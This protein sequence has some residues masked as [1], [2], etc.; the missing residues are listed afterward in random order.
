MPAG[1]PTGREIGMRYEG[2]SDMEEK[3]MQWIRENADTEF[4]K[5]HQ[6]CKIHSLA[7]YQNYVPL[8]DY[9]DYEEAVQRMYQGETNVLTSYPLYCFV[10]TSGSVGK[11]KRIPL[12]EKGLVSFAIIYENTMRHVEGLAGKHLHLSVFPVIEHTWGEEMMVSEA[13]YHSLY[14]QGKIHLD[15]YVG[16]R[17]LFFTRETGDH[18]YIKLWTALQEEDLVSV[19]SIYLYDV[20]LFFRYLE[21]YGME[22]LAAMETGVIPAE[23]PLTQT[24]KQRLLTEYR[25]SGQRIRFLKK[26]LSQGT[27]GIAPRIWKRLRLISGIGGKFFCYREKLLRQYTGE[28]PWQ[29]FIYGSS[30]CLAGSAEGLENPL[31]SLVPD[32]GYFEFLDR[33]TGLV[34][35]RKQCRMQKIYE[36]VIT[37]RSGFYRYRSGD[38]V[39]V[40]E[41]QNGLPVLE[42]LGRVH[43]VLNVAG[44]KIDAVMLETA[45][46]RFAQ[47]QG[48]ICYDYAVAVEASRFPVGYLVYLEPERGPVQKSVQEM[49]HTFDRI[50]REINSDYDDLRNQNKLSMPRIFCLR[51]GE[52]ERRRRF[53]NQA[54]NKPGRT[55]Y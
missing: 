43:Q 53:R 5:E 48:M 37:N 32:S 50:L 21:K 54:Q 35:S 23:V 34:Y 24:M 10:R 36:L 26:E 52:L 25:P 4:G 8:S 27:L 33:D 31:Y 16:G 42:I 11:P 17:D 55:I 44:E 39:R 20:L 6:F 1:K 15:Q 29:Y 51:R 19:Q 7:D 22:I 47:K 38:L 9:S 28:I 41:M 40:R 12:T 46:L 18:L 45:V 13:A 14:E 2:E 30:E 49:S 3:L